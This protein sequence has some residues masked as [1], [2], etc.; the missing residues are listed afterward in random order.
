M[1]EGVLVGTGKVT[2]SKPNLHDL[3]ALEET[4]HRKVTYQADPLTLWGL[5]TG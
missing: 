5:C 2:H 4:L 1:G 3:M